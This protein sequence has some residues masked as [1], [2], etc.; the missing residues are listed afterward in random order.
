MGNLLSV[1]HLRSQRQRQQHQLA[2]QVQQQPPADQY[3]LGA[4]CTAMTD[5]SLQHVSIFRWDA[6]PTHMW[7]W[8][9]VQAAHPAAAQQVAE[10]LAARLCTALRIACFHMVLDGIKCTSWEPKGGR[11]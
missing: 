3:S 11:C 4:V 7:F 10:E 8:A 6:D 9:E 1:R 5:T 2:V